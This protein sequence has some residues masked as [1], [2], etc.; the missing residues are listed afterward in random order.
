MSF[1][2]ERSILLCHSN[3]SSNITQSSTIRRRSSSVLRRS[4][5]TMHQRICFFFVWKELRDGFVGQPRSFR[6]L[7]GCLR[8]FH[9]LKC[10]EMNSF[11][12]VFFIVF[13]LIPDIQ[14]AYLFWRLSLCLGGFV[15]VISPGFRIMKTGE[16]LGS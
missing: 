5:H 13:N 15:F 9:F 3:I 14:N 6:R 2:L 10:M 4:S 8:N 11:S 1:S 16:L 12:T 7:N